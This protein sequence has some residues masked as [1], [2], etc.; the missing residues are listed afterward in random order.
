MLGEVTN[1]TIIYGEDENE[2]ADLHNRLFK[3]EEAWINE[4]ATRILYK[5]FGYDDKELKRFGYVEGTIRSVGPIRYDEKNKVF[6]FSVLY[7]TFKKPMIKGFDILLKENYKNLKQVTIAQRI[8]DNIFINTDTKHIF[9][10]Q[11]YYLCVYDCGSSLGNYYCTDSKELVH[12]C[13][14]LFGEMM[15]RCNSLKDVKEFL[16]QYKG[17]ASLHTFKAKY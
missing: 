14:T 1:E 5:S 9:H 13:R 8:M 2:L 17:I 6:Y 3:A 12:L 15:G 7:N 4:W 16:T 10:K 11:K